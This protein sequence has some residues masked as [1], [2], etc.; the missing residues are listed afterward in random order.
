MNRTLV[1][2]ILVIS[3]T[4]PTFADQMFCEE[5]KQMIKNSIDLGQGQIVPGNFASSQER[6]F[7]IDY[8]KKRWQVTKMPANWI[9]QQKAEQKQCQSFQKVRQPTQLKFV[10]TQI[11]EAKDELEAV[12]NICESALAHGAS[13][14]VELELAEKA[15][16]KAIQQKAIAQRSLDQV[17]ETLKEHRTKE[18]EYRIKILDLEKQ[19]N[20][21]MTQLK[22]EKLMLQKQCHDLLAKSNG[23]ID[24]IE[25]DTPAFS[26]Q[27][28]D[29][30]EADELKPQPAITSSPVTIS[31]PQKSSEA[32]PFKSSSST[33]KL[34]DEAPKP[35][36]K[37]GGD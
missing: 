18:L 16:A 12:K 30:R 3:I 19:Y 7:A 33:I 37:K 2:V 28:I 26:A 10:Q 27:F 35:P 29:F 25:S 9:A 31:P 5:R 23:Y 21:E 17:L 22:Y 13:L 1:F 24:T 34:Q 6:Q 11:R 14:S 32:L 20:Q 15:T 36:I 4:I 8:F